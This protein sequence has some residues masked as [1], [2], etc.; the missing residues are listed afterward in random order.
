MSCIFHS[1]QNQ[2]SELSKAVLDSSPSFPHSRYSRQRSTIKISSSHASFS[3]RDK[4]GQDIL[5]NTKRLRLYAPRIRGAARLFCIH[6]V[7]TQTPQEFYYMKEIFALACA[8]SSEDKL[9]SVN[10][11]G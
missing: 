8:G 2:E 7:S 10:T 3:R 4:T 5:Y 6:L 9:F 1:F 11:R